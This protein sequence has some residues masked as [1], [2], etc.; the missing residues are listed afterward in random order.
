MLHGADQAVQICVDGNARWRLEVTTQ[1]VY[2]KPAYLCRCQDRWI[3]AEL[4]MLPS[5]EQH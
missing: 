3:A 5:C 1:R 4:N 2:A